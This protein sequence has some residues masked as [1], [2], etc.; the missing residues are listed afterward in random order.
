MK[1]K[2]TELNRLLALSKKQEKQLGKYI[3]GIYKLC[4]PK[5]WWKQ[6]G[7]PRKCDVIYIEDQQEIRVLNPNYPDIPPVEHPEHSHF[8]RIPEEF[9]CKMGFPKKLLIH[10]DLE[11]LRIVVSEEEKKRLEYRHMYDDIF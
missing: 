7:C 5:I 9:I 6:W 8:I 2:R 3:E 1:Y 11:F 10:F 4:F